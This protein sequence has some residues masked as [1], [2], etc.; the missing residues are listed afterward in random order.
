MPRAKKP[1]GGLAEEATDF[2]AALPDRIDLQLG[3]GGRVVI[4]AM[5]RKAMQVKEGDR[6]MARVVDGEL[7]LITPHM[8]I[9]LAQKIV[10]ETI[11]GNDS[12]VD[13]LMENRRREVADEFGED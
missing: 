5:F 7:R 6:L 10:R 3:P 9:R 2:E 12:L 4:P 8:G 13:T 11:P 1:A